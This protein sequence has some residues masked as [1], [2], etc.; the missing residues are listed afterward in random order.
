LAARVLGRPVAEPRLDP[1]ELAGRVSVAPVEDLALVAH[2]RLAEP[3]RSDVLGEG[4]ELLLAHEGEEGGGGVGL[5]LRRLP[6]IDPPLLAEAR[7]LTFADEPRTPAAGLASLALLG[8]QARV[9]GPLL[10]DVLQQRADVQAGLVVDLGEREPAAPAQDDPGHGCRSLSG[11]HPRR[12]IR[13][14]HGLG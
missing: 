8:A 13:R 10:L 3:V 14:R 4:G 12:R 7:Q 9:A 5:H 1:Y 6:R 11:P 2:D